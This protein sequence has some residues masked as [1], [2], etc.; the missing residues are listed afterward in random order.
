[1][2][3]LYAIKDQAGKII[4]YYCV[5]ILLY[6]YILVFY[7]QLLWHNGICCDADEV[8]EVLALFIY[9]DLHYFS[10]AEKVSHSLELNICNLQ[11][12]EGAFD[13]TYPR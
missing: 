6:S 9:L 12:F 5:N 3:F 4:Y 13:G 11:G 8:S 2:I 7:H 1:M 10:I